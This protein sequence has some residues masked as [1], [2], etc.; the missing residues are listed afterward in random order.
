MDSFGIVHGP[1]IVSD[2]SVRLNPGDSV[3]FEWRAT[4]GEDACDVIGYLV[5]ENTGYIEE[6]LDNWR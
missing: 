6:I 5:D 3:S 2:S 1:A 4:G